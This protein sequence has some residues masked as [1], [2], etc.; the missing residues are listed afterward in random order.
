MRW[1]L[2]VLLLPIAFAQDCQYK[3][4]TTYEEKEIRC[5]LDNT[6]HPAPLVFSD[7]NR[8]TSN[9]KSNCRPS[10][11]INNTLGQD[12][13]VEIT[14]EI[15]HYNIFTN[16]RKSKPRQNISLSKNRKSSKAQSSHKAHAS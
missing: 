8:A 16:E 6:E 5:F 11:T 3:D 7:F 14:F 1:I 4:I 10:V 2:L 9:V 12:L 15:D 13:R